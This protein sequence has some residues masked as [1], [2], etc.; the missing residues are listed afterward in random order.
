MN[1]YGSGTPEY[2]YEYHWGRI[3][4]V[5]SVIAVLAG[6]VVVA[7]VLTGDDSGKAHPLVTESNEAEKVAAAESPEVPASEPSET[8]PPTTVVA[9]AP[10]T[11]DKTESNEITPKEISH[12]ETTSSKTVSE[13]SSKTVSKTTSESAPDTEHQ[14]LVRS[15]QSAANTVTDTVTDIVTDTLTAAPEPN[16]TP[17]SKTEAQPTRAELFTA[18]IKRAKLTTQVEQLEPGKDLPSEF[19]GNPEDLAK[20]YF[21]T[22]VLGQAGKTH[23]HR[24]YHNGELAAKVPIAIGSDRWRCYSS[25]FLTSKQ[26]GDW[27][28][29]VTDA[30]GRLLAKS[31]FRFDAGI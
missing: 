16:Q 5:I 29:Q 20:V 4:A 9:S 12:Q 2:V 30:K 25:K 31:E 6:A 8:T 14:A 19:K 7:L 17:A 24:W 27:E 10:A 1:K 11:P 3:I 21:Y 15:S 26:A 28:V 22:E 23:Y 13:T 18:A